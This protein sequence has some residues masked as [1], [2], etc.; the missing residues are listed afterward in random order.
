MN[1]QNLIDYGQY[2]DI[3][4][5]S[6]VQVPAPLSADTTKSAIMVRCGLL[7][8]VYSEPETMRDMIKHWF[9]TKQWTFEHL[10]HVIQAE[11]S[12]IENYDRYEDWEESHTGTQ[13]NAGTGNE[14]NSGTDTHTINGGYTDTHSGTDTTENTVSAYNAST[15]QADTKQELKHGEALKNTHNETDALQHGHQVNR[16]DNNTRTDDLKD[17]HTAHLHGNIGVTTN[18]QMIN[19]E[20]EL[21]RHFDIYSYIAKLFEEDMMLMIY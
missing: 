13:K 21:L 10:I 8:P 18:Q 6:G 16:T 7:T 14:T 3:D 20:L 9:I 1:L 11:Y 17:K 4:I 19:E 15:Y 2:S 5:F 12:P